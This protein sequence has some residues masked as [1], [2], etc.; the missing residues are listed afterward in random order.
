MKII[1]VIVKKEH[2]QRFLELEKKV[3]ENQLECSITR[4]CP[5]YLAI[6]DVEPNVGQVGYTSADLRGSKMGLQPLPGHDTELMHDL[7]MKFTNLPGNIN[8]IIQNWEDQLIKM[9]VRP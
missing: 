7:T 8:E 4:R 3:Q 6:L 5:V 9:E 1:D 2:V